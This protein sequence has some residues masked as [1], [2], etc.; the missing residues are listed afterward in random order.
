MLDEHLVQH[1]FSI[2]DPPIDVLATWHICHAPMCN[3]CLIHIGYLSEFSTVR[4]AP[5]SV[6]NQYIWLCDDTEGTI[7]ERGENQQEA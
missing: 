2:S 3:S 7:S 4:F 1:F 5:I 6:A